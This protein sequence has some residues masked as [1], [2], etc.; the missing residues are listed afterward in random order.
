MLWMKS[1]VAST[2]GY[3]CVLHD[4]AHALVF[5]S[6]AQMWLANSKNSWSDSNEQDGTVHVAT[7]GDLN[8]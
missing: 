7:L 2:Q 8:A 6:W 5:C 3:T 1:I 4:E